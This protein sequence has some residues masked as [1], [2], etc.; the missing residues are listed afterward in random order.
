MAYTVKQ[1][2]IL[3][4]VTTR[5]LHHYDHFGL[6]KPASN[7]KNG[8]RQYGE[9]ELLK[10]QQILF[11]RELG[12]SLSQIKSILD[13]PRFDPLD[14]LSDQKRMLTIEIRRLNTL[15]K[16]IHNTIKK[17]KGQ[18]IMN[19]QD[20]YGGLTKEEHTAYQEEARQKWGN[21]EA[22]KESQRRVSKFTKKDWDEIKSETDSILRD[23]VAVMD[24]GVSDPAVQ[25][26]IKRHHQSI[27]RFYDCTLEIYRGLAQMYIADDRFAKFYRKYHPNL[28]EFLSEAMCYYCDKKK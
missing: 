19:D 5:T 4:G 6:L 8:Y 28:P 7:T 18:K 25:K 11:F 20:L 14:A 17:I 15:A 22:F 26:I 9:R 16:T 3:A 24:K 21:T 12:F 23:L 1:L 13:S 27:N 2:A 10:L